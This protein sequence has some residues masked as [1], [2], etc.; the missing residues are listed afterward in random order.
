M[1]RYDS[2]FYSTVTKTAVKFKR[3]RGSIEDDHRS[4]HSKTSTTDE[5]GDLIHRIVLGD[6]RMTGQ[7][8][9][10]TMVISVDSVHNILT[11]ILGMSKLSAAWVQQF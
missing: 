2:P 6:R 1:E 11:D 4:G 8:I 10:K 3:D 7:D 5:Q 9:D